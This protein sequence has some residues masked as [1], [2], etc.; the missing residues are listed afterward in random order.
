M[1]L[2]LTIGSAWNFTHESVMIFRM[3]D[4]IFPSYVGPY[5]IFEAPGK[6][7]YEL[8]L[9]N[10]LAL[11]YPFFNISVKKCLGEPKYI[12]PLD[13]FGIKDSL[14]YTKDLVEISE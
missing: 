4:M 6:V 8:E 10:D 7:T 3:K 2:R 12:V 13:T 5:Q 9:P 14:S 11:V 1:S